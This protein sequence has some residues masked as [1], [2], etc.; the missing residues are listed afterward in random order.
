MTDWGVMRSFP[1][2]GLSSGRGT[3]EAIGELLGQE[4]YMVSL[5]SNRV[6][7]KAALRIG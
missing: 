1:R 7:V 3:L 5:G 6:A 4:G 2:S